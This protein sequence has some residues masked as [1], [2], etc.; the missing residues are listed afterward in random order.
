MAKVE[1]TVFTDDV[2]GSDASETVTFG[3]DGVQYEIDLS[4][5][6]AGKLREALA[7]YMDKGRKVLALNGRPAKPGRVY[8]GGTRTAA[9]VDRE[10]NKAMRDWWAANWKAADLVMPGEGNAAGRG[11]IPREVVAAYHQHGGRAVP[12]LRAVPDPADM[13]TSTGEATAKAARKNALKAVPVQFAPAE[14]PGKVARKTR[15]ATA[16]A[17]VAGAAAEG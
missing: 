15:K 4:G 6:N 1:I 10:Q 7:A 8:Q 13:A 3:L 9:K 12:A 14:T 5:D 17:A 16:G 2:D 11:R